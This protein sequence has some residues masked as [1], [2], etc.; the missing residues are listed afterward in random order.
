M[1]APTTVKMSSRNGAPTLAP[2]HTAQ[3]GSSGADITIS[4]GSA[5]HSTA[6]PR[7]GVVILTLPSSAIVRLRVG[8]AVVAVATDAMYLGPAVYHLPIL[9]GERVSIYG[10]A[11]TGTATVT[12]AR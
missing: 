2:D 7:R 3:L 9:A 6:A 4:N 12:M 5:N 10:D 11:S 1:T 8:A